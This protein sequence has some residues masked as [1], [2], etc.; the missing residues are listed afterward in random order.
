[1]K[2][3]L[4]LLHRFELVLSALKGQIWKPAYYKPP[5]SAACSGNT[6]IELL[7]AQIDGLW[8][9]NLRIQSGA[10]VGLPAGS[11]SRGSKAP[12]R[13]QVRLTWC[14]VPRAAHAFGHGV[15][16]R[17]K[18]PPG[19]GP[20]AKRL[21]W[22]G[23]GRGRNAPPE[24]MKRRTFLWCDE[25]RCRGS[26]TAW[27]MQRG[28]A[29]VPLPRLRCITPHILHVAVTAFPAIFGT[30]SGLFRCPFWV[31][32]GSADAVYPPCGWRCSGLA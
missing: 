8:P 16:G 25:A 3:A 20:A 11:G 29:A 26:A 32:P 6:K 18:S 28:R 14:R 15:Q 2:S 5:K 22:V 24:R 9:F 21:V 1:M 17:A 12:G 13:V 23:F 10:R 27:G 4:A 31:T 7:D 30:S 19:R